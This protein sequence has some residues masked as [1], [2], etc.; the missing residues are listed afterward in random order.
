MRLSDLLPSRFAVAAAAGCAIF[1]PAAI[2]A[3]YGWGVAHHDRV[4]AEARAVE[5]DAAINA[6]GVGFKD[7][8]TLCAANLAGAQ[9]AVV[10]QNAAVDAMAAAALERT[11]QA[12]A[13]VDAAQ[14]RAR[15]AQRQAQVLISQQPQPGESR[16]DAADRLILEQVK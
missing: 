11:R 16:C 6:P 9:A 14:A 2:F 8:L 1:I 10:R 3:A 7:R 5:L 4:Q 12:Q 15:D 13:A